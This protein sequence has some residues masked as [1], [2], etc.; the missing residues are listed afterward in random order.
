MSL[1]LVFLRLAEIY[2]YSRYWYRSLL[3]YG[4]I[5]VTV[6]Q[7]PYCEIYSKLLLLPENYTPYYNT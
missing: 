4:G 5:Y 1:V 7:C 2:Q 3:R 6:Y